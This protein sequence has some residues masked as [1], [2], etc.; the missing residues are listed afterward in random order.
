MDIYIVS[1][2]CVTDD[3]IT[4]GMRNL[5][6]VSDPNEDIVMRVSMITAEVSQGHINSD[7][8][9]SLGIQDC[10]SAEREKQHDLSAHMD[11][12]L[13]EKD[14]LRN[15]TGNCFGVCGLTHRLN[16]PKIDCMNRLM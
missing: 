9:D 10:V 4:V 3:D 7:S 13:C 1:V 14:S 5:A 16:R 8:N 15:M 12:E 11:F 6:G 2:D